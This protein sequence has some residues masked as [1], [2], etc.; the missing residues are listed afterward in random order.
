MKADMT[1][2]LTKWLCRCGTDFQTTET[3]VAECPTCGEIVYCL[4]TCGNFIGF[5][6]KIENENKK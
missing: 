1:E 3:F 5:R 4:P 2:N 6:S